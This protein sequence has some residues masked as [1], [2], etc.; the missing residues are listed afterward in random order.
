MKI[1]AFLDFGTEVHD[2]IVHRAVILKKKYTLKRLSKI[3]LKV[4]NNAFILSLL[5]TH[6]NITD[7]E[8]SK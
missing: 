6:K 1:C 8:A 7:F 5:K 3:I 2:E 4:L